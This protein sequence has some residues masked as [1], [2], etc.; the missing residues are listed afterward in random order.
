M[1]MAEGAQPNG[2]SHPD[3]QVNNNHPLVV[4]F[5]M[6]WK[7]R[8]RKR[9]SAVLDKLHHNSQTQSNQVNNNNS[10][11]TLF[12]LA[13]NRIKVNTSY[14][15]SDDTDDD[16]LSLSHRS[17]NSSPKISISPMQ[18]I[19][20]PT[21]IE[22]K[23]EFQ[24]NPFDLS[25]SPFTAPLLGYFLH[26]KYLPE[27][28]RRRTQSIPDNLNHPIRHNNPRTESMAPSPPVQPQDH[29]LDLSM[30]TQRLIDIQNNMN[31]HN[32]LP[33]FMNLSQYTNMKPTGNNS[34]SSPIQMV[35]VVR[36]DMSSISSK[37]S[38][39][40]HYNIELSPVVETMPPGTD[41]AFVC[42]ICGQMFSLHDRLAKHMASR[43]K[44]KSNSSDIPKTYVCDV[45]NRS[46]A[47]SDMLTRH[48][49]L[50]TGIKPYTCKVCGQVFSRSDHLSTH[51]R[52][53]TGN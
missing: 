43:H 21:N 4:N 1:T 14:S 20:G 19:D 34:S 38:V 32:L 13:G 12:D 29:P 44:S 30:K 28:I 50:H 26:S 31:Q 33:Q 5:N 8:K 16:N 47:R 41:V 2:Y 9:L 22:I 6:P 45:C 37:Q 36:G 27:L 15:N 23:Q 24:Q 42:P 25:A 35:P 52:T 18:V 46:F 39:G 11:E 17:D 51:Q 49:R 10:G 7:Q 40:S 48:M 3:Q 53:H